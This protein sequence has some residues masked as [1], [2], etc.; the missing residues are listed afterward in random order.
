MSWSEL[1]DRIKNDGENG[2]DIIRDVAK[3][4]IEAVE[5]VKQKESELLKAKQRV[6]NCI[7]VI[8]NVKKIEEINEESFFILSDNRAFRITPDNVQEVP[9]V[10]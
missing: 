4:Y 8:N 3:Q 6:D 10:L 2:R 5:Q 7:G 1:V 9:Y